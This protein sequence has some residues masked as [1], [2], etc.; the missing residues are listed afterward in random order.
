MKYL[1]QNLRYLL[2]K[3]G[4]ERSDWTEALATTLKCDQKRARAI[5]EGQAD[6]V[7]QAEME[8]LFQFSGIKFQKLALENL[9]ENEDIDVFQLNIS[10]LLERLPHGKK[11]HLADKLGVD[12]TTISRWG[13]GTQRPTKRKIRAILDYFNLPRTMDLENE[14]VFLSTMPIGEAEMKEWLKKKIDELDRETL[15]ELAPALIMILKRR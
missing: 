6:N 13:K 12:Q 15:R 11:K 7:N 4:V 14:S 5:L 8:A 3:K 10:F 9:I 1:S 2:L